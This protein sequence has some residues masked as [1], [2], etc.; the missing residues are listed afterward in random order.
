M[1]YAEVLILDSSHRY[2]QLHRTWVTNLSF[3]V[4]GVTPGCLTWARQ[5]ES[6]HLWVWF[7]EV[8]GTA[9]KHRLA[10]PWLVRWGLLPLPLPHP[11][12]PFKLNMTL[13]TL[14]AER[15]C[16]FELNVSL[17]WDFQHVR[18]QMAYVVVTQITAWL[19]I[20]IIES[21]AT[22]LNDPFSFQS[23]PFGP[24]GVTLCKLKVHFLTH[25]VFSWLQC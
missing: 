10:T 15:R 2:V 18:V 14:S 11:A 6:L 23:R 24:S 4:D 3:T 21:K 19:E 5:I 12:C 25:R 7:L 13:S 9:F 16:G 8:G 22:L 17:Y 1:F 20:Y